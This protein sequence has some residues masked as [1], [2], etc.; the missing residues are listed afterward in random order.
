MKRDPPPTQAVELKPP[1]YTGEGISA[2]LGEAQHIHNEAKGFSPWEGDQSP[3]YLPGT[4]GLLCFARTF[5]LSLSHSWAD[6]LLSRGAV[7]VPCPRE[8]SVP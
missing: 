2:A 6:L 1:D 7:V 3:R 8:P 5:S 4:G